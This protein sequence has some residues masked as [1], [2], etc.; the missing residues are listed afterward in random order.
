MHNSGDKLGTAHLAVAVREAILI[1]RPTSTY[2]RLIHQH[3]V[4]SLTDVCEQEPVNIVWDPN[5]FSN[6]G[7]TWDAH[8]SRLYRPVVDSKRVKW[9]WAGPGQD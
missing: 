8:V 9:A 7:S 6:M 4:P 3:K 5:R 2:E 1:K